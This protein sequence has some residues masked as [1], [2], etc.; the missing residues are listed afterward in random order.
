M[1]NRLIITAIGFFVFLCFAAHADENS[2]DKT[3]KYSNEYMNI[4]VGARALGMSNSN[5]VSAN[6]VTAGYWNPTGLLDIQ[7]NLQVSLMHSEYFAGI[8][9][10]NYLGLG[11]KIDSTSALSFNLIRFSV[12][13]IPNTT[14]LFDDEGNIDYNRITSFST[15]DYGFLFSYAKK[16]GITG[17]SVGGSAKIIHRR[18]GDFLTAWGFGLDAS[19][20]Y[21]YKNWKFGLLA[22]DVTTTYTAFHYSLSEEMEENLVKAGNELPGESSVEITLPKFLFGAARYFKIKDNFG[23]LGEF[24][25]DL[26]TDGLR[27]VLI[28]SKVISIDPHIGFEANYKQIIFLRGGVG[29]LQKVKND[30][31]T[32]ESMTFQ[33]NIGIGLKIKSLS[34]DYAFTDIGNQSTALYS[35]VFS[36]KLDIYKPTE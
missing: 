27:N 24:N 2:D 3:R 15:Q 35:H 9:N 5:V 30:D 6:D 16:T 26:T 21:L 33:P 31:G 25:A 13:N 22:R 29:N 19:A 4:G 28:K 20:K 1:N 34:L 17:L 12:D 10:Y 11:T 7:S 32:D 14:N 8:A 36:L 23:L 18:A